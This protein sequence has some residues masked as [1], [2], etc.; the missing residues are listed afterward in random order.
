MTLLGGFIAG[1]ACV[2]NCAADPAT[3]PVAAPDT[4]AR[5]VI[6]N[7]VYGNLSD[8]AATTNVTTIVAAMVTND[9]LDLRG[10]NRNFGDPASGVFKQLRVDYT[11]DGVAGTKSAFEGGRLR[12]SANPNPG[13]A[14]KSRLVIVKALYGDLPKGKATDVTQT[15]RELVENNGLKVTAGYSNFGDPAFGKV[16]KLRVDYKFDGWRNSVTVREGGTLKIIPAIEQAQNRKRLMHLSLWIVTGLLAVSAV[17]VTVA[18]RQ[19]LKA[20]AKAEG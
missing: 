2:A 12:I 16:K 13:P 5:L 1:V 11:I 15:V 14:Q 17:V 6:V 20:E 18:L 4:S 3:H 10:D 9:T 19:R 8:P 7:A